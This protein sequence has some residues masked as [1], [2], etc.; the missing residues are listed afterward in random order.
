MRRVVEI[1]ND[2]TG[3]RPYRQHAG[4]EQAVHSFGGFRIVG[5]GIAGTPIDE[6]QFGIVR[7]GAPRRPAAIFPG[8][9]VLRPCLGTRLAGRRNGVT[10]PQLLSRVWIPA[11]E[12]AAGGGFTARHTGNQYAIGYYA[13]ARGVV[14]IYTIAGI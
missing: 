9:A 11:V 13:T 5:F 8:V 4:G 10:A 2:L 12:E 1:A 7:T 6:I 14:A 3:F